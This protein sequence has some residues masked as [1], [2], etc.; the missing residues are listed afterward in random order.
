ML[1]SAVS[2]PDE[3]MNFQIS[4]GQNSSFP[5]Y[6]LASFPFQKEAEQGPLP[7]A[8]PPRL[9]PSFITSEKSIDFVIQ[10]YYIL[11]ASCYRTRG[12]Q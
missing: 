9:F 8:T 10:L 11:P 1:C 12:F 5:T 2:K 3:V 6:S 7:R 4:N